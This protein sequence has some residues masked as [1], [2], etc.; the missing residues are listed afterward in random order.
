MMTAVLPR[1][2][3]VSVTV[4]RHPS[5]FLE[6][7]VASEQTRRFAIALARAFG[8]AIIFSLP[9]IMTMEMWWLGL[10]MSRWRLALLLVLLAPLLVRLS[11][12]VGFEETFDWRN[13]VVDAFVALAV[14]FAASAL[15]LSA[16][17]VLK[18]DLSADAIVGMI[19][20]QAVPASIGAM[21]AQSLL[22]ISERDSRAEMNATF[23]GE[24][25][26]MAGGALFL[27]LNVAPTE[28]MVLI[29]FKMTPWHAVA[30]MGGSL[31]LM[32]AFVY[33]L[34]FRGQAAIPQGTPEWKVFLHSTVTGY[35]LALLIS[36]YVL[37][38]FGRTDGMG[39]SQ[40][41]I[42]TVVLAFPAAIGAAAA[43]LII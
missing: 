21:L 43:R 12:Y 6:D 3:S 30:L 4:A 33:A 10:H 29:A 17:G 11:Y 27:A 25:F 37:W 18:R 7:H 1:A 31:V 28:E 22:G 35:A 2:G 23:W 40:A 32:H 16:L 8:G 34:E 20:L 9:L 36:A 13:D 19:A 42:V 15:V 26:L 39:L 38:T 14:A 5:L 24:L 41:A